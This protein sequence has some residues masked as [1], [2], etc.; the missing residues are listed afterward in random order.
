M[1]LLSCVN[2]LSRSSLRGR[3]LTA[4]IPCAFCALLLTL[5]GSG[6]LRKVQNEWGGTSAQIG[7]VM[8]QYA[9]QSADLTALRQVVASIVTAEDANALATA[10]AEY[11]RLARASRNGAEQ[12]GQTL[13]T[14]NAL[15]TAKTMQ[16]QALRDLNAVSAEFESTLSNLQRDAVEPS[17][18]EDPDATAR[19]NALLQQL[20][21]AALTNRQPIDADLQ[22]LL[23]QTW[24]TQTPVR[25]AFTLLSLIN[26]LNTVLDKLPHAEE[27]T[28]APETQAAL[29]QLTD[30]I[31]QS[32]ARL[33]REGNVPESASAAGQLPELVDKFLRAKAEVTGAE[34]AL[35]QASDQ[36]LQEATATVADA[37]AKYGPQPPLTGEVPNVDV[38]ETQLPVTLG[39]SLVDRQNQ[40][41]AVKQ[42]Y[43]EAQRALSTSLNEL[44]TALETL[45]GA[46]TATLTVADADFAA[47]ADASLGLIADHLATLSNHPLVA[48]RQFAETSQAD[49]SHSGKELAATMTQTLRACETAAARLVDG[50]RK[51]M[52]ADHTLRYANSTAAQQLATLEACVSAPVDSVRELTAG[53]LQAT[54]ELASRRHTVLWLLGGA[55]VVAALGAGFFTYRSL[56]RPIRQAVDLLRD[57]AEGNADLTRRLEDSRRDELGEM[58][59]WFNRFLQRVQG[60]I[61][62]I[63]T[64][65]STLAQ[66]A[67]A[68]SGTANDLATG[69]DATTR[70]SATVSGTSAQIASHMT[71]MSTSTQQ[72]T[73]NIKTIEQAVEQMTA[74]ISEVAANAEQAANV[75]GNA[76][77]LAEASNATVGQLGDAAEEID[78]VIE[79]IQDIAEQINLLALNATIE[80]ARAGEAGR[81]FAVVA[82]EV[83][84]LATQTAHATEDIR[85]RI[86]RIQS[87][88]REAVSSIGHVASVIRQVND[89]SATIATAFEEQSATVRDIAKNVSQTSAAA[90]QVASGVDESAA[91]TQRIT[92]SIAGVDEAARETAFGASHAQT[93]AD[94]L[95]RMAQQLQALVGQFTV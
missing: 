61:C 57:V 5:L 78:K 7:M 12:R 15:V 55:G 69:A 89:V 43:D 85:G 93:A 52:T 74:G 25:E 4:I 88:T 84:E 42:Q 26:G 64:D 2:L 46:A 66:A 32:A 36:A 71:A 31:Q 75:A 91:A 8:D 1:R 67:G 34:R 18:Q 27:A 39:A 53:T 51:L 72:M 21:A 90:Q 11:Q 30:R 44:Q 60:L 9:T 3:L 94:E 49:A 35:W 54:G 13:S 22:I 24:A 92:Q 81:G 33:T 23:Q 77:E 63:T 6:S 37:L 14:I 62:E 83:K 86:E 17:A 87:S 41:S 65:A 59:R 82:T 50:Q 48:V 73:S 76:A 29:T 47:A 10:Q 38:L 70:Q 56:R 40:A 79:T 28:T 20:N 80:A 16:L 45:Q 95:T 58:A 68:L 19:V